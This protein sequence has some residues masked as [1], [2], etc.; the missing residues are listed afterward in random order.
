[1]GFKMLYVCISFVSIFYYSCN[2]T[3]LPLSYLMSAP[4]IFFAARGLFGTCHIQFRHRPLTFLVRGSSLFIFTPGSTTM[5]RMNLH[6]LYMNVW[7]PPM[8]LSDADRMSIDMQMNDYQHI[9]KRYNQ[10]D[11]THCQKKLM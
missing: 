8:Y 10:Q 5:S 2:F 9:C 11:L 7:S 6:P 4:Q 1:M 3:S